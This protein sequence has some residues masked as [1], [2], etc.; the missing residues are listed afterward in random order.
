MVC[1]CVRMA[2]EPDA[3]QHDIA[4]LQRRVASLPPV[5]ATMFNQKVL[6][7]REQNAVRVDPR[8][9]HC[10][11]CRKQFSTENAYR[12]HIASKKHRVMEAKWEQSK[13]SGVVPSAPVDGEQGDESSDEEDEK[14]TS[15]TVQEAGEEQEMEMKSGAGPSTANTTSQKLSQLVS[16]DADEDDLALTLE[17]KLQASRALHP[18]TCLFCSHQ[19]ASID[20]NFEHMFKSH[21][22]YVPERAF[23]FDPTGLLLYLG[24]KL[25]VGNVCLYCEGEFGSL[26][27]V[28]GHMKDKSHQKI[29]YETDV[30][31]AEF[32]DYYDFST[33]YPDAEARAARIAEQE[34]RREARRV[35]REAKEAKR[36]QREQE[37]EG[38]GGWEEDEQ[39]D[40]NMDQ[41]DQ[42]PDEVVVVEQSDNESVVSDDTDDESD[43]GEDDPLHG[44]TLASDGLSLRL[45]SGR[46]LGHRSLKV[47]YD[48][49]F[50]P[51]DSSATD[52][53]SS[54]ALTTKLR[55][56]RAKLADPS[57]SLVP[58]GGGSGAFG[59]GQQVVKARNAGE[60]KWAKK[61]GKSHL[62]QRKKE[63]PRH[64]VSMRGGNNQK[65]YRDMLCE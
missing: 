61:L 20:A 53:Q 23:L 29:R 52:A 36:K 1:I 59:K 3:H 28:R 42:E 51:A 32:A 62:D 21:S 34:K 55:S 6:E 39:G 47:Y 64:S 58:L 5:S 22:F 33:S 60:A 45:P 49:N 16:E 17:Q 11:A 12:T 38:D 54:M 31:R 50:R 26:Q 57:L 10:E 48:Q 15:A 4:S 9:M 46:T 19:S 56:V 63:G 35:R 24:E 65:H 2:L 14:P 8:G 43:F 41:D 37:L 40:D 30:D 13:K 25:A 27:A 44:V 7:K 18:T